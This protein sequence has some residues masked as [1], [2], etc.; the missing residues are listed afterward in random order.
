MAGTGAPKKYDYTISSKHIVTCFEDAADMCNVRKFTGADLSD[1][2]DAELKQCTNEIN[3]LLTAV[4]KKNPSRELCIL[5]TPKGPF[6]A[7]TIHD[8]VG[9]SASEAKI[10]KALGLK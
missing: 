8:G 1:F 10:I 3:A 6:L 2:H 9:S 7:W 4:Q 5:R